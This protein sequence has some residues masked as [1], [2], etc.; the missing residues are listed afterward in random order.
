MNESRQPHVVVGVS[1]SPASQ[2]ALAWAAGEAE[3]RG[4]TL[5]VVRAWEPARQTA[6]YA[7]VGA[8]PTGTEDE[9]AARDG[10]ATAMLAAFGPVPPGGV[11]TE[12]S[13]GAPERVIVA[14]SADADLLVLGS[15]PA[16]F[17]DDEPG[18][19]VRACLKL[20]ICP[21]VVIGSRRGAKP[22]DARQPVSAGRDHGTGYRQPHRH[23][24]LAARVSSR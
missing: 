15:T 8:R 11:T 1:G 9:D 7:T 18:S 22:S 19:I 23:G 24:G 12:L 10:L 6:P 3:L 16:A 20:V 14:R 4:A 17:G 5:H 13:A 21:V 2:A